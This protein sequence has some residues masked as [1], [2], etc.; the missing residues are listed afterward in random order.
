MSQR[1]VCRARSSNR[2][3]CIGRQAGSRPQGKLQ[4][5]LELKEGD[6]SNFELSSHDSLSGKPKPIAIKSHGALEILD[7]QSDQV[8]DGT[9]VARLVL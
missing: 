3:T 2:Q 6:S 8:D 4:A 7:A 1:K 5:G 9:H